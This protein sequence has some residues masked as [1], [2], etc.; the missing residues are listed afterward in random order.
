MIK[1]SRFI[2]LVTHSRIMADLKEVVRKAL[3]FLDFKGKTIVLKTEQEKALYRF[4]SHI[5][6]LS[7]SI[8][9]MVS[10][11]VDRAIQSAL[12]DFLTTRERCVVWL[13]QQYPRFKERYTVQCN[14]DDRS[15]VRSKCK[16]W[17]IFSNYRTSE[18]CENH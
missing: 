2:E 4:S 3:K 15:I 8:S 16:R 6:L 9:K 18:L 12:A 7:L 10:A 17:L 1:S 5:P 14:G 11:N 13:W